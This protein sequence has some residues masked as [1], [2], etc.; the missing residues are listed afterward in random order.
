MADLNRGTSRRGLLAGAAAGAV[1]VAAEGVRA[2]PARAADG[3]GVILGR[4]N[5]AVDTTVI[6]ARETALKGRSSTDDGALVGE[7]DAPDGY[8][9]R[10]TSP[11]IGLD[12]VGNAYGVYATSDHGRGVFG[13]TYDGIA[14][15]AQTA[16]PQGT[17]LQVDGTAKF[18][19]SGIAIVPAGQREV[20]VTG[21]LLSAASIVLA[22]VQ[23][24]RSGSG[25]SL[26]AAIPDAGTSS[27]RLRLSDRALEDTKIGWFIVS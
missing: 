9:V 8:G 25:A 3:D 17:A 21:V 15:S 27:V 6:N 26:Q 5:E 14:L 19:R 20:R 12:A 7:N 2:A 23:Q 11:Y 24:Y 10:A 16:V 13:Q 22:T 18:S 1:V 4:E